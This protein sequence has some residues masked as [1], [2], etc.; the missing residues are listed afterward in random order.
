M[1]R[2]SLL[3][4]VAAICLP[5][6]LL[7]QHNSLENE[8][9]NLDKAEAEAVLKHDTLTLETIWADNFTVNT[10]LNVVNRR[11]RGDR[12]NFYYSR[13]D[14]TTETLLLYNDSLVVTMGGE[15]IVRKAPMTM[16][17]QTLTRRYTHVWMKRAGKWQLAARHAN[18]ICPDMP[19]Q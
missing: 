6:T 3:V 15:V 12:V 9:R 8:I 16:A 4:I 17:G 1:K 5:A 13:F 10:P 11:K 18:F 19:K 14:R 2:L 7:A